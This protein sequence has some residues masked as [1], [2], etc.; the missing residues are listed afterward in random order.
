MAVGNNPLCHLHTV[1]VIQPSASSLSPFSANVVI[2]IFII[3]VIIIIIIIIL[4]IIIGII[5]SNI[6]VII[7]TIGGIYG[8]NASGGEGRS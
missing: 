2:I 5:V 6:S 1:V 4:V 8:W 3:L 7:H